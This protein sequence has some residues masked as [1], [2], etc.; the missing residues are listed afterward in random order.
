MSNKGVLVGIALGVL[1]MLAM[2]QGCVT[3]GVSF[4]PMEA[5]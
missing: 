3:S 4:P 1:I 2:R 5:Y